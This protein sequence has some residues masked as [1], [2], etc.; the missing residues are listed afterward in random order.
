MCAQ[1]GA[2]PEELRSCRRVGREVA[3]V[4][5]ISRAIEELFGRLVFK[6]GALRGVEFSGRKEARPLLH[7][8]LPPQI[9]EVLAPRLTRV[10]VADVTETPVGDRPGHV[11]AL[12][13]AIAET[14]RKL[15]ASLSRRSGDSPALKLRGEREAGE[16]QHGRCKVDKIDQLTQA[17]IR[18][19]RCEVLKFFREMRHEWRVRAVLVEEA[20]AARDR[21]TVIAVIKNNRV[22]RQTIGLKI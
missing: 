10:I 12:V 1:R 19:R 13:H 14:E 21:P 2:E 7:R 3:D 5:R 15:G 11:V 9:L 8:R 20:L 4:V 22:F 6:K 16:A 17:G 18:C